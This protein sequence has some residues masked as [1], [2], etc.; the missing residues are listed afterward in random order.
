VALYYNRWTK[1]QRKAAFLSQCVFDSADVLR[2][3]DDD[4]VWPGGVRA[5]VFS[6]PRSRS[7][8]SLFRGRSFAAAAAVPDSR[9]LLVRR[10]ARV[11]FFSARRIIIPFRAHDIHRGPSRTDIFLAIRPAD[12]VSVLHT[13][14]R[15][16]T[17]LPS[18]SFHTLGKCV[19]ARTR[20]GQIVWIP[21]GGV[22]AGK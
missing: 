17:R 22:P 8:R 1:E 14:T 9:V 21:S 11:P 5:R 13:H 2:D 12:V 18:F 6:S 20:L 10:S 7:S 16:H 3:D 15:T 19:A 4:D